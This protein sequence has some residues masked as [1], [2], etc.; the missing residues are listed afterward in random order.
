QIILEE[1][2]SFPEADANGVYRLPFSIPLGTRPVERSSNGLPLSFKS[3]IASISYAVRVT[4]VWVNIMPNS[5][6]FIVPLVV[7]PPWADAVP[8]AEM[9]RDLGIGSLESSESS[10]P[11]AQAAT[12]IGTNMSGGANGG[13]AGGGD[14]GD[15]VGGGIINAL[16]EEQAGGEVVAG[17]DGDASF[18]QDDPP[19]IHS[20]TSQPPPPFQETTTVS[21]RP[22]M[23]SNIEGWVPEQ[24]NQPR[25]TQPEQRT[26]VSFTATAAAA[27][28]LARHSSANLRQD[29]MSPDSRSSMTGRRSRSNS[30]GAEADDD[31]ALASNVPTSLY[32][33]SWTAG[34]GGGGSGVGGSSGSSSSTSSWASQP[35][36][37]LRQRFASRLS[38]SRAGSASSAGPSAM[39][40]IDG[41]PVDSTRR[42]RDLSL[43]PSRLSSGDP[44]VSFGAED[45]DDAHDSQPAALLLD[46][47]NT[48]TGATD[49]V[50]ATT[51]APQ[52]PPPA[53][54]LTVRFRDTQ[55]SF[56]IPDAQPGVV[57]AAPALDS[58]AS[59]EAAG[60]MLPQPLSLLDRGRVRSESLPAS[61]PDSSMPTW[62]EALLSDPAAPE[63]SSGVG[64]TGGGGSA[65]GSGGG[66]VRFRIVFPRTL[67]G[68][69]TVLPAHVYV[70][71]L[72]GGR[73]VVELRLE[74]VA[75]V[76]ARAGALDADEPVVLAREVCRPVTAADL[77]KRTL[78]LRVPDREALGALAVAFVAPLVEVFH[79][80]NVVMVVTRRTSPFG[81]LVHET[82]E[83]GR[84]SVVMVR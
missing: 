21:S 46:S 54:A 80:I 29:A 11:A 55:V 43:S 1:G 8:P 38:R 14:S 33:S 73:R 10:A 30:I 61:L 74:L 34:F 63:A 59:D 5:Y 52:P 44:A 32:S 84:V 9:E 26:Q 69:G 27:S 51:T 39:T 53:Q 68:P 57:P 40:V 36:S 71:R 4:F 77:W 50:A 18:P 13:S 24:Q 62:I 42:R 83:L 56:E 41:L 6:N 66:P 25:G 17:A 15:R 48:E 2:D 22:R 31:A 76:R 70:A 79:Y 75:C 60:L 35:L 78:L 47:D 37:Q 72:A 81:I 3:R 12:I 82:L 49:V 7:L 16:S 23:L 65:S 58:G 67:A 20:S 28:R 64:G 45:V 19:T